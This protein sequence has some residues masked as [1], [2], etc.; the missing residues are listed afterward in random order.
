MTASAPQP[1]PAAPAPSVGADG[2][3]T[4]NAGLT[5]AI[6]SLPA[7]PSGCPLAWLPSAPVG[8]LPAL[9]SLPSI[10]CPVGLPA[11]ALSPGAIPGVEAGLSVPAAAVVN[12][13]PTAGAPAL[14][15]SAPGAAAIEATT[16][17]ASLAAPLDVSADPGAALPALCA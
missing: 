8:A 10:G 2:H 3:V 12:A 17:A 14:G 6:A 5:D 16:M 11:T 4:A 9:V 7:L 1:A 15:L 13:C